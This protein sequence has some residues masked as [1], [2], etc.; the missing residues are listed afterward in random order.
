[1]TVYR[2]FYVFIHFPSNIPRRTVR[3]NLSSR[4]WV[5]PGV[6]VRVKCVPDSVEAVT[7]QG[8]NHIN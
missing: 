7:Y 1:M 5:C 6:S 4:S 3:H 8:L 2:N